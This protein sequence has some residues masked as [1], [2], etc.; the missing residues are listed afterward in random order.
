MSQR[1][2]QVLCEQCGC[3]MVRD[4]R[5]EHV[6]SP[7]ELSEQTSLAMSVDPSQVADMNRSFAREGCHW[8]RDGTF[9]YTRR[10]ARN[11]AMRARGFFDRDETISPRN[12]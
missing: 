10:D 2:A 6:S 3:G 1:N 9:A 4:M 11:A 12:L 8:R 5:A 7:S